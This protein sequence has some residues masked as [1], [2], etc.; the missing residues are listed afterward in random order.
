MHKWVTFT[1][2]LAAFAVSTPAHAELFGWL[3]SNG[4]P[5]PVVVD[6]PVQMSTPIQSTYIGGNSKH[7]YPFR[8]GCCEAKTSCCQGIWDG[9]C[10]GSCFSGTFNRRAKSCRLPNGKGHG[11]QLGGRF[12][13][14]FGGC[15]CGSPCGFGY[16]HSTCGK[17]TCGKGG[18]GSCGHRSCGGACGC[19]SCRHGRA[20]LFDWMHFGHGKG[21]GCNSCSGGKGHVRFGKGHVGHG[22]GCSSCGGGHVKGWPAQTYDKAI[23]SHDAST[24]MAPTPFVIETPGPT[25]ALEAPLPPPP[26]HTEATPTSDRSAQSRGFPYGVQVRY[27][28]F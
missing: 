21:C 17:G 9:Y 13:A 27:L 10:G 14:G 7:G 6:Q 5:A 19:G 1:V 23:Q 22:A 8:S 11:C 4:D 25:P 18:C 28:G 16:G 15:G 24:Q 12:L 26:V 20:G 2:A 3:S